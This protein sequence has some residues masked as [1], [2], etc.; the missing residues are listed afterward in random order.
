MSR[1]FSHGVSYGW[2]YAVARAEM[3]RIICALRICKYGSETVEP[4]IETASLRNIT[5]ASHATTA[6][7]RSVE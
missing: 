7:L 3:R 2:T 6:P 4:A 1:R 5:N